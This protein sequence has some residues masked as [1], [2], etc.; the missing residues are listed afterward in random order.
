[1]QIA[2]ITEDVQSG[3]NALATGRNKIFAVQEGSTPLGRL[4]AILDYQG[5]EIVCSIS[6]SKNDVHDRDVCVLSFTTYR[7]LTNALIEIS[8]FAQI[9]VRLPLSRA[10]R[11]DGG[12]PRLL[13]PTEGSHD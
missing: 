3:Y 9:F 10:R 2:K 12:I 4:L 6:N 7:K 13:P 5:V 11:S 8:R 1:M